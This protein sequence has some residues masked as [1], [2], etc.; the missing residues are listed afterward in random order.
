MRG[1]LAWVREVTDTPAE[2]RAWY[3]VAMAVLTACTTA[4]IV[5]ESVA[6]QVTGLLVAV[7]SLVVAT[8]HVP[9]SPSEASEA[10]EA[11]EEPSSTSKRTDLPSE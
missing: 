4:G 6:A 10:S 7:G 1:V 3:A 2:R 9:Q 8:A 5:T 11:S